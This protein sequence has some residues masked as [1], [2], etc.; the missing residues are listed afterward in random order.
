MKQHEPRW[1]KVQTTDG[2]FKRFDGD[3]RITTFAPKDGDDIPQVLIRTRRGNWV[4]KRWLLVDEK[5]TDYLQFSKDQALD[6]LLEHWDG[7]P[8]AE[9]FPQTFIDSREI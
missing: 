1:I 7:D 9:G 6:W 3:N 5:R 8:R 4:L 2:K